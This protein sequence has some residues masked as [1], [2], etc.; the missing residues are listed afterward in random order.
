MSETFDLAI[1][2]SGPGGYRAAVL[3][4]LRGLNVV[5][6]EKGDWGGCCLNRG[7]VPKKD[8]YHTARTVAAQRHFEGRGISGSLTAD[9]DRAWDHQ[10][11]VVTTVRDSYLGYMKHLK[12]QYRHGTARFRDAETLEVATQDG[13]ETV[14]ARHTII[15]T[16]ATA[17]VPAP[18]A[19]EPSRVL[20]TDMLFDDKPPAGERV[21]IIGSGVVATEFAWIFHHLG[22]KVTW[23]SR[24]K[25]LSTQKFSPQALGTL[26]EQLAADGIE[27]V[28]VK[29]YE[30]VETSDNDVIITDSE[31][32]TFEVDWVL[33]GTGRTPHTEGLNLDEIGVK[34]D[35]RGFV[36]RRPTLQTDVDNIY[37]IGDVASEW[38][39]ANHALADA[40]IAVENI[41]NG[42]TREQ[43]E[44]FVPIAIYSAVEMARLGMD[45]DDAEDEE[46]EPAVGFAAFETSPRA[47]GQDEP[48]GFVRLIGD[49]DTG[50]LLGG[51]VIGSDA[52]ELIHILSLAP[53]RDTALAWLARGQWNHPARAEE[54]LNATETLASKWN[55]KSEIFGL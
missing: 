18:F 43:D 49:M 38:Q 31:G 2:G 9:M 17:T 34:T 22:K 27:P 55:L 50:A 40:T 24:S 25:P 8:W 53:D 19:V 48:E 46:L 7:C 45:E 37:A 1:I 15:A 29:G 3:G 26:K 21:A 36:K 10:K 5:I 54:F 52:G 39:T 41:Q 42:N 13:N 20:T 33:L 12:I 44:R 30:K 35:A 4:A 51:E 47:L 23:L 28:R 16:G 14:Q 11:E 32:N 6:V